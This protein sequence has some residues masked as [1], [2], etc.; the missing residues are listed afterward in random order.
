MSLFKK[1]FGL[2]P[3][4]QKEPVKEIKEDKLDY[5][6]DFDEFF[7]YLEKPF[8]PDDTMVLRDFI[9]KNRTS[10][11][12]IGKI[13]IHMKSLEKFI[14][15]ATFME[16]LR[17]TILNF[18]NFPNRKH[19]ILVKLQRSIAL[20][21][22]ETLMNRAAGAYLEALDLGDNLFFSNKMRMTEDYIKER[23]AHTSEKYTTDVPT[24]PSHQKTYE[25]SKRGREPEHKFIADVADKAVREMDAKIVRELHPGTP[26]HDQ[27]MADIAEGNLVPTAINYPDSENVKPYTGPVELDLARTHPAKDLKELEKE[28]FKQPGASFVDLKGLSAIE[29]QEIIEASKRAIKS[30]DVTVD[31]QNEDLLGA[32]KKLVSASATAMVDYQI[33]KALD[34]KERKAT[35]DLAKDI[36]KK[37]V[38]MFASTESEAEKENPRSPGFIDSTVYKESGI[39][40]PVA[41]YGPDEETKEMK[42]SG[43]IQNYVEE[44]FEI[45]PRPTISAIARTMKEGLEKYGYR[46]Y[47]GIPK[48]EHIGRAIRHMY[49]YLD[50]DTT[51]E[52]L[53]HAITRLGFAVE[54]K[55][56][57]EQEGR[58]ELF[59][60]LKDVLKKEES[61]SIITDY[62]TT[63]S[64]AQVSDMTVRA[65]A[66]S[67]FD[68]GKGQ[69][70]EKLRND[71][72]EKLQGDRV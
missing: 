39:F 52:H 7:A 58:H 49:A 13:S 20:N 46:N 72:V 42:S 51:E 68:L 24:I 19:F 63:H 18:Y 22:C 31:L 53:A 34:G 61:N 45:I 57:E 54:M 11:E 8:T 59:P 69:S 30:V 5:K 38:E 14:N 56:I 2:N 17:L 6:K 48:E 10:I 43:A 62:I 16:L 15:E 65:K 37:S 26:E 1:L 55:H 70:L 21:E 60:H 71:S 23:N 64:T 28:L 25:E 66:Q 67:M 36:D 32:H 12:G 41:E 29:L 27:I 50:G 4:P 47:M 40:A 9:Y 33:F 35:K 3:E 44:S